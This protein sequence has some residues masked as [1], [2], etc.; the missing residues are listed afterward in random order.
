MGIKIICF[1]FAEWQAGVDAL[2]LFQLPWSL[3]IESLFQ[4]MIDELRKESGYD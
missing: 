1:Y 4:A 3:A 2:E